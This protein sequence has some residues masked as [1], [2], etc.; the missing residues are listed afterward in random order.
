MPFR[1]S[2]VNGRRK[3]PGKPR[4]APVESSGNSGWRGVGKPRI[5][6]AVYPG[7]RCGWG[8]RCRG[9]RRPSSGEPAAGSGKRTS[10]EPVKGEM[11]VGWDGVGVRWRP[12]G[13]RCRAMHADARWRSPGCR[14][15]LGNRAVARPSGGAR[16]RRGRVAARHRAALVS[17]LRL[18]VA[19]ARC[20]VAIARRTP[21][22]GRTGGGKPSAL[23]AEVASCQASIINPPV[24]GAVP[25]GP[26]GKPG[27]RHRVRP[28]VNFCPE[29]DA[30][31]P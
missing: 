6:S 10:P 20:R 17:A 22:W 24:A 26:A 31:P 25:G 15:A 11:G 23:P 19:A 9:G 5:N 2:R 18:V 1:T 7:K 13:S 8:S 30:N 14:D 29:D 28:R 4:E 3:A 16:D 12:R 27:C 21:E